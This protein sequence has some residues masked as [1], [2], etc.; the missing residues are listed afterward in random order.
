MMSAAASTR[1][2]LLERLLDPAAVVVFDGAM[3]TMIYSR[4]VFINQC[5]DELN[6]R[7]PELIRAIHEEYVRAGAEVLETN[8]FGANRVKLE[9]H[10]L[11]DQVRDINIA[12]TKLAR[13]AAGDV[14]LVAGAV[15]PIGVRI[16]HPQPLIDQLKDNGRMIIP[17]GDRFA[18]QLY[19]LEKKNGQ[20]KQS[21]TLPVRLVPMM[22]EAPKQ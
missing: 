8:T 5:Y 9:Q 7:A 6:L 18:Q 21:A 22:S 4:G 11:A 10:G 19:L 1:A 17:V 13:E 2:A 16:E 3:G 15:G 20:L 14:A 12:A